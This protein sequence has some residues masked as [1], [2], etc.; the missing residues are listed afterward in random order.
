MRSN[1]HHFQKLTPIGDVKLEIYNEAL[2]FV[3]ANEDVKNIK[4]PIAIF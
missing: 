4:M 3:F 2:D 1:R